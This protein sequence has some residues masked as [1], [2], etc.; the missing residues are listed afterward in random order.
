MRCDGAQCAYEPSCASVQ[1]ERTFSD[2]ERIQMY[3][4][5]NEIKYIKKVEQGGKKYDLCNKKKRE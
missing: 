2:R 1:K 4:D 3:V 5:E